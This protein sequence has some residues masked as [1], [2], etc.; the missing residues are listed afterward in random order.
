MK[1]TLVLML[2]AGFTMTGCRTAFPEAQTPD[3]VYY[4]P[5][6]AGNEYERIETDED[7]YL[8]MK[9]RNRR[10]WNEL[11]DWYAYERWSYGM[12]YSYGTPYHPYYNWNVYHNPYWVGVASPR[13]QNRP[14]VSN[15]STYQVSNQSPQNN[16]VN[17]KLNPIR[18]TGSNTNYPT[19]NNR[20]IGSGLRDIFENG[21]RNTNSSQPS[22]RPSSNTS[23]PTQSAPVRKF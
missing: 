7:R 8:R 2:L 15:L 11:N 6:G 4:S 10:D 13:T 3:D 16:P 12:N 19:N 14:R 1:N 18:A 20:T 9:V 17:P 23:S 21:N 5:E 22:S